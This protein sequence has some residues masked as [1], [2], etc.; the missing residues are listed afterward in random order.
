MNCYSWRAVVGAL[1]L[2]AVV[3]A[4]ETVM[5]PAASRAAGTPFVAAEALDFRSLLPAPPAT[6]SLAAEVDLAA[7]LQVQA[8]R[9]AEQVAWAK[10][11]EKDN[12]F[13]HA[14][15]LGAWFTPERLP[16]TAA[17]FRRIGEDMRL[18][19]GSAKKPF[20]RPRPT[21][22]DPRVEPC[23]TV[24]ASTSYPS[25]SGM[26]AEVWARLLAEILPARRDALLARAQRAGW[27]RVIGGVHFPS[28]I[29]AGARLGDAY[30]AAARR[31]AAFRAAFEACRAEV[32]AAAPGAP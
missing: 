20:L 21:A 17:F 4:Q 18:L 24:P 25:G 15:I 8:W 31:N 11:V 32:S 12:V 10:A 16:A 19:D 22:V 26:Q 7:V 9:T 3:T 5:R 1:A 6:G 14:E 29:V 27:G 2:G 30:L 28:D 23:V 13:N